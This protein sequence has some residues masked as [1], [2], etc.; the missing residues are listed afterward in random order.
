MPITYGCDDIIEQIRACLRQIKDEFDLKQVRLQVDERTFK[1]DANGNPVL[2]SKLF[3]AGANTKNESMFNIFD[4]ALRDSSYYNR[5]QNLFEIFEKQVGTSK[6]I[7]TVPES[8]G[9]TA[10]EIKA[11]MYDTY[12]LITDIRKAIE[13][14]W[15]D[16]M[17]ICNVFANY[18]SL[19]PLGEYEIAFD[20]SYSMIE[21]SSE[22]W[23]QLKDG[24]AMGVRSKAET[25]AWQTGETL[26]EAQEKIDEITA[27]EPNISTLIGEPNA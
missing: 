7:L 20:W 24:Q 13:N 12:S 18:Y 14:F 10:T 21:S 6:G 22:T 17:Y 8:R 3:M 4:P 15:D 27:K 16:L 5:L 1:R 9:A 23:Q 26:D 25:R 2:T 11:G 19:S